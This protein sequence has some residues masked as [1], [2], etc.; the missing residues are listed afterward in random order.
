MSEEFFNSR[1]GTE[2]FAFLKSFIL[3]LGSSNLMFNIGVREGPCAEVVRTERETDLS[4]R[5]V[6][7]LRMLRA[8]P[9]LLF[10]CASMECRVTARRF[11]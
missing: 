6:P 8:L 1:Q 2:I 4:C 9:V 5:L 11:V 10:L 3:A 7:R